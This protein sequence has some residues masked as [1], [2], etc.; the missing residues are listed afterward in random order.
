MVSWSVKNISEKERNSR[1]QKRQ[2]IFVVFTVA[3]GQIE[4]SGRSLISPETGFAMELLIYSRKSLTREGM[5][6]SHESCGVS[7][8]SFVSHFGADGS[9]GA[10]R[11]L[12]QMEVPDLERCH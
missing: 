7:A 10:M 8:S 6:A 4:H 2:S 11:R 9:E 5:S 12:D 3:E 1:S